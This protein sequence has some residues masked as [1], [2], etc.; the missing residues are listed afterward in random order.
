ML[1]GS[2]E[3]EVG[4]G[5]GVRETVAVPLLRLLVWVW[6]NF[7]LVLGAGLFKNAIAMLHGSMDER[8]V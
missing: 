3:Q 5:G 1:Y 2:H 6:V 4:L 7:R 8:L